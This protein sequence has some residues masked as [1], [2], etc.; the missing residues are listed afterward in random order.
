M[1][2]VK[3]IV[4]ASA[5]LGLLLFVVIQDR[6]QGSPALYTRTSDFAP[7]RA[8]L[9]EAVFAMVVENAKK[10]GLPQPA[11]LCQACVA[12]H[13]NLPADTMRNRCE[14]AC[15]LRTAQSPQ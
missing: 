4:L 11:T 12:A 5:L 1:R 7:A 2:L 3:T 8:D 15:G 10:A 6:S 9:A 13:L 14:R